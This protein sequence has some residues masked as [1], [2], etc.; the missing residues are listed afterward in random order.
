[1]S[2]THSPHDARLL[3]AVRHADAYTT[4]AVPDT[5]GAFVITGG[6]QPYRVQLDPR[7]VDAPTCTCPDAAHRGSAWCKHMLAV[8]I[9][10]PAYRY[11]LLSLFLE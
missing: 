2:R 9:A 10:Q 5:P 8:L 11:Q 4:A 6:T 7:W 1:M 3:R